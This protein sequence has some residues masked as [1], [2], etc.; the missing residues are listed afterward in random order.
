[1]TIAYCGMSI[2]IHIPE[3]ELSNGHTTIQ[4]A[5]GYSYERIFIHYADNIELEPFL[6]IQ[7]GDDITYP[8][9]NSKSPSTLPLF[10]M[11]VTK[12]ADIRFTI[13]KF[14]QIPDKHY[15]DKAFKTNFSYW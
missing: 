8:V 6:L 14:G 5:D 15:F 3:N 12:S 7:R 10:I 13:E 2:H 4:L 11:D 1:M 9:V